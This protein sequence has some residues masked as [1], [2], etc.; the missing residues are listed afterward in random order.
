MAVGPRREKGNPNGVVT[1][2]KATAEKLI[3]EKCTRDGRADSAERFLSTGF[4]SSCVCRNQLGIKAHR[5]HGTHEKKGTTKNTKDNKW[6]ERVSVSFR[7]FRG[8]KTSA[9]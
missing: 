1:D 8:Q 4:L 3:A 7:V 2:T 5:T 6:S 9:T